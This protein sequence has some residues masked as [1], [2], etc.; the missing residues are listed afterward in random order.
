MLAFFIEEGAGAALAWRLATARL[1]RDDSD[2][3]HAK[4]RGVKGYWADSGWSWARKEKERERRS[5][6]A[7]CSS[8]SL[9]F[10]F[11]FFPQKF[12]KK[13]RIGK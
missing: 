5:W 13:G 2:V 6:V 10:A 12:S 1:Q 7:A 9:P 11:F 3:A 4:E 8:F